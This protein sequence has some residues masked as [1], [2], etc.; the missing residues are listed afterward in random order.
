[1]K[2]AVAAVLLAMTGMAY[3]MAPQA[4]SLSAVGT[5]IK[6]ADISTVRLVRSKNGSTARSTG[7]LRTFRP[8]QVD[9]IRPTFGQNGVRPGYPI[10]HR[11]TTRPLNFEHKPHDRAAYRKRPRRPHHVHVAEGAAPDVP[12][13]AAS[14]GERR[15]DSPT[16]PD[17]CR[18]WGDRGEVG[19]QW[20]L[21]W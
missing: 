15:D 3:S 17:F 12:P 7:Q 20:N 1:M 14:E 19:P 5:G 2:K 10:A 9:R 16:S 8:S 11:S 6:S 13:A 18:Y 4:A 21:C